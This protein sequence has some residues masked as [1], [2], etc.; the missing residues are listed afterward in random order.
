MKFRL[1]ILEFVANVGNNEELKIKTVRSFVKF[2]FQSID[3]R[4]LKGS[5][6]ELR[7]FDGTGS[8]YL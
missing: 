2:D 6:V 5:T 8:G 7:N 4:P 3:P 1:R